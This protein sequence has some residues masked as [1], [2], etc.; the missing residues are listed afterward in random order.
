MAPSIISPAVHVAG[1][2]YRATVSGA[3]RYVSVSAL[4][5]IELTVVVIAPAGNRFVGC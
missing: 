4:R 2:V 1:D 3:R 5:S